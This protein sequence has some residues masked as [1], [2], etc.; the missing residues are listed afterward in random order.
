MADEVE[1][2]SMQHV[3]RLRDAGQEAASKHAFFDWLSSDRVPAADRLAI[4]PAGAL[5]IMQF[6]DMNRWV[7]RF[8]EPRSEYEWVINLGTLEDEKHSKIFLE[9]WHKLELDTRL[10]WRTSDMLWWLFL[11]PDQETFR[12]SGIEFIRL[13]VDDGDDALVR[14][15]HSEAGEATGHVMLSNTARVAAELSART[16]IEYRYFG[17][18][19]LNLE[20]GHVGNTEGIFETVVLDPGRRERASEACQRM[21]GI[22]DDVFDGFLHY[23]NT[24]LDTGTVPSRPQLPAVARDDWTAPSL[25]IEPRD[26]GDI[27]LLR[28]IEERKE[29][30]R[31]HP[32]YDWLRSAEHSPAEKLRMFIPMWV[33]DILGYRDLTKYALTFTEPASAEEQAVN[34]WASR[35]SQH[36]RLFLSDWE[37]LGLDSV[38]DHTASGALEWLFFDPDMDLHRENMIE[39]AKIALRHPDP[40]LRWWMLV[41]LE[42]TG[43]EFFTQTRPLALAAEAETGGRL[44]YLA[45]RHDPPEATGTDSGFITIS[46]PAPLRESQLELA[47]DITNHVFDSMERQLWRSYAIARAGKYAR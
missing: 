27:Q 34:A 41:A 20:T 31:A 42:S 28:H 11:S 23:A 33:M 21:F 15:G 37:A 24:Y 16:G 1:D 7:L 46:A 17:P 2:V 39:F 5:F 32:F 30:L 45:G 25:V 38:L 9:D 6:R 26:D 18:Y 36:S 19:H 4:G 40:V 44:D 10:G 47:K 35:L 8:P 29:R 14:F 3:M 13:A 12:R 43:E 22:F